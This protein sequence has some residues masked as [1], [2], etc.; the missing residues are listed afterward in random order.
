MKPP[1]PSALSRLARHGAQVK[2]ATVQM[3]LRCHGRA[4]CRCK[5]SG[6]TAWL[7]ADADGGPTLLATA[8]VRPRRVLTPLHKGAI[9]LL[10]GLLVVRR[11]GTPR[12][13]AY[14]EATASDAA[15]LVSMRKQRH[16]AP[17]RLVD[18]PLLLKLEHRRRPGSQANAENAAAFGLSAKANAKGCV[19]LGTGTTCEQENTV[20]VGNRRLTQV[21]LG[22][23]NNDAVV[24]SQLRTAVE[25]WALALP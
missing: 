19:A 12:R 16:S 17:W 21:A 25:T 15:A 8:L 5:R 10:L 1:H 7:P 2:W 3:R 6:N 18:T 20:A 13:G 14:A 24:V 11:W 23:A 22:Q 4:I 9:P